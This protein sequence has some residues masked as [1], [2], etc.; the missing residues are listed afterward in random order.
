MGPSQGSIPGPAFSDVEWR[1]DLTAALQEAQHK[2]LPIFITLRCPPCKQ[3]SFFDA[4][5]LRG[6]AAMTPL[7]KQFVT[8]RITNA[9]EMDHRIL[10]FTDYQDL[11]VSWWGYF[12][13]PEGRIYGVYG[14]KDHLS[15]KTR[16]NEESLVKTMQRVLAHHYDPRRAIWDLEP[17]APNLQGQPERATDLPGAALY[18][19]DRKDLSSQGCIHCHQVNDMIYRGKME[20]PGFDKTR[21]IVPWPYPENLGFKVD[22]EDGLLVASIEPGSPAD[23]AGVKVG[24]QLKVANGQLLFSEAD[25][26]GVLHRSPSGPAVITLYVNRNGQPAQAVIQTA[27]DWKRTVLYWRKSI[28]D[29]VL[30]ATP[31]FF[32]LKGPEMGKGSLS[33]RAF[34]KGKEQHPAVKAGLKPNQVVVGV[35]GMNEDMNSR[36]FLTWFRMNFESGDKVELTVKQGGKT[37]NIE[38][39]L[40]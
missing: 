31:G 20:A 1:D 3:C 13:S 40:P 38:Y 33:L 11:D 17:P 39:K 6:S 23:T 4:L 2:N 12:L 22:A 25:L 35:N 21:D 16:I 32:P 9:A 29:G 28:Y 37:S 36:E 14:G 7:F 15:D 24:D 26:R 34:T 5:V 8:V 19:K 30:G 18:M 10:P 27:E